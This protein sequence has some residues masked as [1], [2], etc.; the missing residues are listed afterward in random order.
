MRA[1]LYR[2]Y[3]GPEVLEAAQLADPVPGPGQ[4][5]IRVEASSV[6]PI[7]WKRAS[8]SLRLLLPVRFPAVPGYDVAGTVAMVGR[9]VTALATGERVHARIGESAGGGSAELAVAGLDVVARLPARMSMAEGAAL[10]LAGMTALQGLRDVGAL[11]LE[12]AQARVLVVGASGGVGHLAVQLAHGAGAEVTG[13]CSGRNAELVRGLGAAAVLDYTRPGAFAGQGGF[14]L[15]LDCVGSDAGRWLPLVRAGGRYVSTVPGPGVLLRQ[16]LNPVR[17]KGV[18]PV[19]LKSNAADLGLL[20]AWYAA[21]RLRV[22]VGARFPLA[23]LG[24]AWGRSRSG[25]AVGKLVIEV[26]QAL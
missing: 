3:G 23:R 10:P 26:A 6:N 4:V 1:M 20:D 16:V 12:G 19:M 14:H 11:P 8:G 18:Y 21:S 17:A 9:G 2:R 24:E 22:V 15:V 5:L 7:D 25:R 13:V